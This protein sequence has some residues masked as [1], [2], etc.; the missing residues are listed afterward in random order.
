LT[1]LDLSWNGFGMEGCHEMGKS[2]LR[3]RTLTYLDLSANRVSFDAFRQLLRGVTHNKILK[4]LKV[5]AG[6]ILFLGLRVLPYLCH[7][8][9]KIGH[10]LGW[11]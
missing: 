9:T 8:T 3:N 5:C 4:V 11:H 7:S 2:L 10:F 6:Y 1:S